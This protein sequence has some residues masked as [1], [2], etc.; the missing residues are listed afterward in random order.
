[1]LKCRAA[2]GE[3]T[4]RSGRGPSARRKPAGPAIENY[5]PASVTED[6]FNA[7]QQATAGR[8]LKGGRPAGATVNLFAGLVHDARTG[9][10]LHVKQYSRGEGRLAPYLAPYDGVEQP[11]HVSFPLDVFD[12][13]VL[14]C[15]TEIDPREVLPGGN[16]GADRVVALSGKQADIE[17]RIGKVKSQMIEGEE[18]P[19]AV[20]VLRTLE[21]KL[22]AV[23]EELAAAQREAAVPLAV[24]WG[25]CQ[26]LVAVLETAADRDAARVKLRAAIRRVVTGV[27]CL[28][29]RGRG[30]RLAAVQLHFTGGAR[31]DYIIV[32][33]RGGDWQ[34]R[35]LAAAAAPGDLDLRRP[36]HARRLEAVLA[37]VDLAALE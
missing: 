33:S 37:S 24:A 22:A 5:Y 18:L 6:E 3:F 28:F 16:G 32:L 14:T 23:R 36:D 19:S 21:G 34:A 27:W 11:S 4:P 25:E 17:G 1:M 29:L 2:F 10:R 8:R 15:L 9:G 35:S 7:G 20:D 31:R 12:A 26:S 13:A 30:D